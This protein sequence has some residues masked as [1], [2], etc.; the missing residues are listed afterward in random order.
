MLVVIGTTN[1][2]GGTGVR[3]NIKRILPHPQFD[4]STAK[5]DIGLLELEN[6][7]TYTKHIRPVCLPTHGAI[8]GR[9][10]Y[11]TGWGNIGP[12]IFSPGHRTCLII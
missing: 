2:T 11:A 10:C 3:H 8:P 5:N 7:I 9:R 12:Y 1:I 4:Y 6:S